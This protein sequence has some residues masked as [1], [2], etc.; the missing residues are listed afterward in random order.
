[1]VSGCIS[2][3]IFYFAPNDPHASLAKWTRDL[4]RF[5]TD[6]RSPDRSA[7]MRLAGAALDAALHELAAL[8]ED[9]FLHTRTQDREQ[10]FDS[11][12][13]DHLVKR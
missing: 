5:A 3:I 10:A 8:L 7:H 2:P 1:V 6:A 9:R 12:A 13:R 4:T 11:F